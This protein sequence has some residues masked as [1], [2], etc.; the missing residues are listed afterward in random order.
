MAFE[1]PVYQLNSIGSVDVLAKVLGVHPKILRDISEKANDSYTPFQVVSN[2][3][4]VRVVHEPKHYLKLIQKRINSRIMS[5]V[6][7]PDYLTGGVRDTELPRDYI[8]NAGIH[9]GAQSIIKLDI[10][11][12]Y[13]NIR[14]QF[15]RNVYKFF[16]R[17]PDLVVDQLYQ[18]TTLHDR[19]PQGGCTSSYLA[20]LV[21]YN[22]EYRIASKFRSKGWA[23]SRL[24]DDIAVSSNESLARHE[25]TSLI[26]DVASMLT[27]HGLKLNNEK[28]T[29]LTRNSKSEDFQVTGLWVKHGKPKLHRKERRFARQLVYVVEK[30]FEKDPTTPEYS[31]LWHRASGK[32]A[33]LQRLGHAQAHSLRS[34]L[35]EIMPLMNEQN[36]LNLIA[37]VDTICSPRFTEKGNRLGVISRI[38]RA[39]YAVGILGRNSPTTAKRL[40]RKITDAHPK[41]TTKKDF[42]G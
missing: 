12:F 32:V 6:I 29:V 20:N 28:T 1:K 35:R 36:A 13:P 2:S 38:N 24:L 4:K 15:V 33:R 22:S 16:F 11:N 39:K 40:R 17:F 25:V 30:E 34:R 21:F 18:L 42:W 41:L 19:I 5:G 31:A 26:R 14:G 37:E 9:S 8:M 10:K 7:F 3:G 27:S 23:Y